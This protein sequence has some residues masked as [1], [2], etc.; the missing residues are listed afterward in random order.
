MLVMTISKKSSK[1]SSLNA[2]DEKNDVDLGVELHLLFP[3]SGGPVFGTFVGKEWIIS[4]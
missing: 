4:H 3:V 1:F 2:D